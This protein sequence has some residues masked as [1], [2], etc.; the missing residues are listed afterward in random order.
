[1][2]E[3]DSEWLW[4]GTTLSDKTACNEFGLTQ[5]EIIR[6]IRAGTLHYRE[7]SCTGT[8]GVQ[9]IA[10]FRAES[11]PE[12]H[13]SSIHSA[14]HAGAQD[15]QSPK[16]AIPTHALTIT[17]GSKGLLPNN[18]LVTWPSPNCAKHAG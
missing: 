17:S 1:M 6:A 7:G 12:I 10:E 16:K 11:S 18:S 8:R 4:K 2:D 5:D 13:G 3:M 9:S 14:R 15:A